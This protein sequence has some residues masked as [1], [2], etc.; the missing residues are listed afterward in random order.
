MT[1]LVLAR[2]TFREASR[3]RLLPAVMIFG[4]VFV[5]ASV[6]IA[7]L[8]LGEQTRIV[9]DLG[10]SAI[11]IFSIILIVM[12]GTSLVFREIEQRTIHTIL[13]QPVPRWAYIL[14][15]FLG[16][17]ATVLASIALLSVLYLGVVALFGGGLQG[18]LLFAVLLV[19]LEAG[20]MTAIA[21]FFSSVASPI[22]AAVF[23]LLLWVSG[24]LAND[25]KLLATQLE[26]PVVDVVMNLAHALLPSLHHFHIR[27]NL[28][29]GAAVDPALI[30][31]CFG[32][33]LLYIAAV[34]VVTV[35]A[36]ERRDF[37]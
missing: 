25:L 23:T 16:L 21:V 11:N 34:I 14:G 2:N 31:Y 1:A 28:L 3:N 7:P 26:N 37:E 19:A 36:F 8:T 12:V 32:Y 24:H 6:L 4:A 13:T 22:L 30:A 27:N 33:A 10:L 9:R 15:K 20:I 5:G 35:V 18:D 29:S 17:Y